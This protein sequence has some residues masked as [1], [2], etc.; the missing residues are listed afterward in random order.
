[1]RLIVL[2]S[3]WG[4][5]GALRA[6][7][8]RALASLRAAGYHGLEA[9]LADIGNSRAQREAFVR[10]ARSQG[11][12]LILSA[13]S[14]WTNYEGI[15]EANKAPDAHMTTLLDEISE[16]ASLHSLTSS[17]T[18]SASSFFSSSSSAA[19]AACSSF[20][21]FSS[22]SSSL[23]TIIGINAHTGTDMWDE[24]LAANFFASF[25][26]HVRALGEGVVPRI[27]HET[28]RGRVLRCPFVT[29]RLLQKIP[30]LRL[31]SDFSHWVI[32]SERL[33]DTEYE[34]S[35][36]DNQMAH[37][38]VHIHARVGTPQ[39][40]Q[41]HVSSSSS[42]IHVSSSSH[43]SSCRDPPNAPRACILLLIFIYTYMHTYMFVPQVHD[44]NAPEF[45]RAR[46][47]F[48]ALWERVWSLRKA[49]G[50]EFVTA[51]MEYGPPEWSDDGQYLGLFLFPFFCVER[52]HAFT[53]ALSLSFVL[54]F[55]R[56]SF[57]PPPARVLS[58]THTHPPPSPPPL[59]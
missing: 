5:G 13:Y 20:S 34:R 23:P 29:A 55:S 16:I 50:D 37:A 40:P 2:R 49:A 28:H 59:P 7:A 8:P 35:L 3:A 1:M 53:G 9:S 17:T 12:H 26:E 42:D 45:A 54:S 44:V 43:T 4:H 10:E 58:P 41:V 51:T 57:P 18:F 46:E 48:Y 15:F 27:S 47:R 19:A 38:M 25:D 36:I 39:M 11:L 24:A 21:S 30:K 32:L 31:T 22:S 6:D 14:S 33:L 52:F 56:F